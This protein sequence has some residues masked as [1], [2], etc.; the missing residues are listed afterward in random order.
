MGVTEVLLTK[1]GGGMAEHEPEPPLVPLVAAE[2]GKN[3]VSLNE[4][5]ANTDGLGSD[6]E[7]WAA[8]LSVVICCFCFK[9]VRT[10]CA[11]SADVIVPAD[12]LIPKPAPAAPTGSTFPFDPLL[13]DFFSLLPAPEAP[14]KV[15]IPL[16]LIFSIFLRDFIVGVTVPSSSWVTPFPR[17]LVAA[18]ECCK[19]DNCCL[20]FGKVSKGKVLLKGFGF[21]PTK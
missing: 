19:D 15:F 20:L 11:S 17:E 5:L 8:M 14:S 13:L 2:L 7:N 18:E 4:A 6:D 9:G 10:I 12:K 21:D 16:P 3:E 1:G